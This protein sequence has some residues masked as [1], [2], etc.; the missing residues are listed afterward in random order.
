[1]ILFV[2]FIVETILQFGYDFQKYQLSDSSISFSSSFVKMNLPCFAALMLYGGT[3]SVEYY[4][5]L[6]EQ[7]ELSNDTETGVTHC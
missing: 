2:Y 1:M 4:Y 3:D 6:R 5:C 7:C